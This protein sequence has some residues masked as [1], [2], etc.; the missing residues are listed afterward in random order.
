MG[1]VRHPR[2]AR[3]APQPRAGEIDRYVG[4]RMRVQRIMLGL[5]QQQT[6]ALI[7]LTYQQVHKYEKGINRVP[8]G[9]LYNI[10]HALS[11]RVDYFFEG[12]D[13][14]CQ[15]VANGVQ[16]KTLDFVRVFLRIPKKKHQEALYSFVRKCASDT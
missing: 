7:N 1:T 16:R 6:A 9:T 3:N 13:G 2:R 4:T 8:A 14:H 15:P 10:A 12:Y 11:V 5:T